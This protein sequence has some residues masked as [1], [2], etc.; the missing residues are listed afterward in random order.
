MSEVLDPFSARFMQYALAEVLLLAVAGALLGAQIVLRRLSF[1]AHGAG[2]ATFP[3][4]VVAGPAGVPP[5]LSALAVSGA[6]AV[7]LERLGRAA[8]TTQDAATALLLVAALA[9]GIILASDVLVS[10]SSV[11]QLLFG[12][13]LGIGTD[14][15][16][17]SAGAVVLVALVTAAFDRAWVARGFD[18]EGA[19]ALGVPV[20]VADLALLLAVAVAVVASIDA[21]GALL[22]GAVLVIPA[23]TA[24][25]LA[26]SVGS[27]RLHTLW[28]GGVEGAAGLWVAYQLD[29]PPG[30][31]IAVL[32]GAMFT[33]VTVVA[34]ARHGVPA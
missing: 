32:G 21:V 24:R 33:V 19:S 4:L 9:I 15:L 17:L 31:V 10:G 3:G 6:F 7:A 12:S 16:A 1:F 28:I 22:V 20:A 18:P 27:L 26:G 2:T 5:Q 30:P 14:E 8:R 29:L 13:L 25:P 11:D 23:A 34:W